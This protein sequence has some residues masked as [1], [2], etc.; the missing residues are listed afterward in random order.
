MTT[1]SGTVLTQEGFSIQN[2]VVTICNQV[3]YTDNMGRFTLSHVPLGTKHLIV[4]H[5]DY[6]QYIQSL[7]IEEDQPDLAIIMTS[8]TTIKSGS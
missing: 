4:E 5:R 3:A 1:I 8:I 7:M 2:A 6:N